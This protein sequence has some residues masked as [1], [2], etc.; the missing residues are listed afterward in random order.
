M[1]DQ[2]KELLVKILSGGEKACR[3]RYPTDAEWAA[4]TRQQK[5]VRRLLGRGKSQYEVTGAEEADA[6]LL[7]KIRL[8][9]DGV[10][11]DVAEAAKV[12]ERLE[13][14]QVLD[15]ERAGDRFRIEMRVAGGRV[16]HVLKIPTQK[17]VLDYGRASVHAVDGRREQEIRLALEPAAELWAKVRV[18][19]EGYANAEA[20]PIVHK[21]VAVVELLAQVEALQEEDDPEE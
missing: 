18:A 10:E 6:A 19:V 9:K 4:R 11:F 3:V 12:I 20:V 13:R 5:A 15:V 1:F 21:D 7:A 2:S 14:C 8:D 16:V 17:D